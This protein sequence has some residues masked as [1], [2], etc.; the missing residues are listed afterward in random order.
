MENWKLGQP[1]LQQRGNIFAISNRNNLCNCEI[2]CGS[3]WMTNFPVVTAK[4]DSHR[5]SCFCL[6]LRWSQ[7]LILAGCGIFLTTTLA[8][9]ISHCYALTYPTPL[10]SAW[11]GQ[12]VPTEPALLTA[13]AHPQLWAPWL[14]SPAQAKL[15]PDLGLLFPELSPPEVWVAQHLVPTVDREEQLLVAFIITA[16]RTLMSSPGLLLVKESEAGS[17]EGRRNARMG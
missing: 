16:C 8:F 7:F 9:L 3:Y 4:A 2:F 13:I 17:A 10:L 11:A 15:N 6:S 12:G 1:L 14:G 5:S